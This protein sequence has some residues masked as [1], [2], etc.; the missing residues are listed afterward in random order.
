[1]DAS[2]ASPTIVDLLRGNVLDAEL[3]A[4]LWLLLDG[5]VPLVV[6]SP[7]RSD[8]ARWALAA[9]LPLAA[10]PVETISLDSSGRARLRD[11]FAA[12]SSPVRVA[13]PVVGSR[14]EE[15]L[16]RL[17]LS[18]GLTDDRVALLGVVCI[19]SAE[20]A[21]TRVVAAHYL[22]PPARD[23]GGHIQRLSPAVLA[24]WDE[25]TERFEHFGWGLITELAARV[26]RR[27]GD[28]E[29][30]AA[31]RA[32]ALTGLAAAAPQD[33]RIIGLT[34]EGIRSGQGAGHS[35]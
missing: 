18:A 28:F 22:R 30:E 15:V 14:L 27:S 8:R 29:A 13:L 2:S 12:G 32:Q 26:G 3:A 10:E 5:G 21:P 34:L 25:A 23:V 6:A 35:H 33:R 9:L 20:G 11:L 1:M 17:R 16:E 7:G 4:E 24:T 19:L 31:R